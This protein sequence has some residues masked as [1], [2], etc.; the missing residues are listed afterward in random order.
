[1]PDSMEDAKLKEMLKLRRISF[2]TVLLIST[3][4]APDSTNIVSV[5]SVT[6]KGAQ[7]DKG[8]SQLV[9]E[10]WQNAC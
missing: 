10:A 8:N 9:S 6:D 3:S 7:A 2:T 4:W 1:M 5:R